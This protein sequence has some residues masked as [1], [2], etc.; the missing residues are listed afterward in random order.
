[1]HQLPVGHKAWCL[2]SDETF[3]EKQVI[4][5]GDSMK[6]EIFWNSDPINIYL[7]IAQV[8]Q[9]PGWENFK[10]HK[11]IYLWSISGPTTGKNE[12]EISPESLFCFFQLSICKAESSGC[13]D[14]LWISKETFGS[15]SNPSSSLLRT[16]RANLGLL[17]RGRELLLLPFLPTF[18]HSLWEP[19]FA[20]QFLLPLACLFGGS[21]VNLLVFKLFHDFIMR[22][23]KK[24]FFL[25]Q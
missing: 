18:K 24:G 4:Y 10:C 25:K 5:F 8:L 6:A 2:F 20:E 17:M 7:C 14:K 23:K 19:D 9:A 16:T 12:H 21:A 3:F 11:E 15:V 13:S 1:M 22:G